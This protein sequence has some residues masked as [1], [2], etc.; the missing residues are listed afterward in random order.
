[1]TVLDGGCKNVAI[2]D[3]KGRAKPDPDSKV[4]E[5]HKEREREGKQRKQM[6]PKLWLRATTG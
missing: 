3:L 1:M 6:V 4:H 2:T 5:S